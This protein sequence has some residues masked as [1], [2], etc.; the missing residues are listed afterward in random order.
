MKIVITGGGGFIGRKLARRP[1]NA[2]AAK[3]LEAALALV[4][5]LRRKAPV[6]V[7]GSVNEAFHWYS[8]SAPTVNAVP[9]RRS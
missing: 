1:A 2:E 7:A 8:L 5:G 9:S 6:P 3:A 4:Y